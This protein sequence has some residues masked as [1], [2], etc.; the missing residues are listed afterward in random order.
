MKVLIVQYRYGSIERLPDIIWQ[1]K[2]CCFGSF[3]TEME[4]TDL[5]VF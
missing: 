5:R 3:H 1:T 4:M 2:Q